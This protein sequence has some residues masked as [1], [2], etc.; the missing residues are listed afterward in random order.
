[1]IQDQAQKDSNK[2]GLF[3][4]NR[5]NHCVDPRDKIIPTTIALLRNVQQACR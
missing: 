1:M 4:T 2:T 3:W 5:F